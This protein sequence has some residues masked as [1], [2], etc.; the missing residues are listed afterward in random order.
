LTDIDLGRYF[1][2]DKLIH[3]VEFSIFAL[4][5]YRAFAY[6][7]EYLFYRKW[8]W[9]LSLLVS[10]VYAISDEYH[11]GFVPYRET[12]I[13]D[14]FADIM[15]ILVALGFIAFRHRCRMR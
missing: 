9:Y 2:L 12:D 14:L 4:L 13:V 15:G 7:T 10:I 6:G 5:C 8:S 1:L 3:F 11:Q